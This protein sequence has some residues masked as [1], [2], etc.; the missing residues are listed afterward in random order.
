LSFRI[1]T[2]EDIYSVRHKLQEFLVNNISDI[3]PKKIYNILLVFTEFSTNMLKHAKGGIFLVHIL[4]NG[5]YMIFNDRGEGIDI[6]KI[7]YIALS[8][9]STA[10]DSLGFGFSICIHLCNSIGIATDKEGTS[11][12]A[13]FEK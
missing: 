4:S 3:D 11:I 13:F 1:I 10:E 6:E 8:N 7:P 5:I 12:L 2:D 9:Y